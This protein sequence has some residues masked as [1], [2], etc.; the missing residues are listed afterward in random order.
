ME[1][2]FCK[3]KGSGPLSLTTG[4]MARIWCSYHCDPACFWLGTQAPLW[5][6]AGRGHSRSLLLV[7]IYILIS[8]VFWKSALEFNTL[9][10]CPFLSYKAKVW[11]WGCL[12]LLPSPR[13]LVP[14]FGSPCFL[15]PKMLDLKF[16][17]ISANTAHY[18]SSE[19]LWF[20]Q[21]L[22]STCF[23]PSATS[24]WAHMMCWAVD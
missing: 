19:M 11:L 9:S 18:N 12:F 5:A 6:I 10:I 24:H 2:L 17:F 3:A 22:L 23:L 7:K 13:F 4:L 15:F 20:T 14:P 1:I 8:G 21:G 16:Y